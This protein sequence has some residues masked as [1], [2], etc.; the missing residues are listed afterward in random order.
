MEL[1]GQDPILASVAL[2]AAAEDWTEEV[3]EEGFKLFDSL[4]ADANPVAINQGIAAIPGSA[5]TQ[6]SALCLFPHGREPQA[7]SIALTGASH[8]CAHGRSPGA[9]RLREPPSSST[10]RS[11]SRERE[12]L[13]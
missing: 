6:P 10:L 9:V 3:V 1:L 4:Q 2:R 13:N 11:V 12:V 8:Q 5:L 7:R